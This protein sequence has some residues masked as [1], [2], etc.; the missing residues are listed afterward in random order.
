MTYLDLGKLHRMRESQRQAA[1]DAA[2]EMLRD[3]IGE[4]YS[5]TAHRVATDH[6]L[7]FHRLQCRIEHPPAN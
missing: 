4:D 6:L 5:D 2:H 7:A 3:L 1:Q